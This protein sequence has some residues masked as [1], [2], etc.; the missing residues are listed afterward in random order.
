V[1]RIDG[2]DGPVKV[3][4]SGQAPF[5][6]SSPVVVEAGH[7]EAQGS[8]YLPAM[9]PTTQPISD[10]PVKVMATA[11]I[12][13]KPV[14]K[15]LPDLPKL[16]IGDKPMMTVAL[17]PIDSTADGITVVPGQR[18]AA[19]L[20]VKRGTHKGLVSFEVENLPHGVIVADI[21]L[22]GVL[23]PDGQDERQIFL[24]C[25]PWVAPQSRPCHAR[26]LQG[27]NPTSPPVML[28]VAGDRATAR[29]N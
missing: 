25:A 5:V 17:D 1:N 16:L 19:W 18:V 15:P 11:I 2:F 7:V 28:H 3:D 13:G 8:V 10:A 14:S 21:G 26:A 12:D 29:G 9:W 20:R 4:L 6:I 22:S 24:K 27:D 23:I